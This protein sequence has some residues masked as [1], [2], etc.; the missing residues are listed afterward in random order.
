MSCLRHGEIEKGLKLIYSF[1]VMFYGWLLDPFWLKKFDNWWS[2]FGNWA[3][4]SWDKIAK[5]FV[6]VSLDGSF[7]KML[8]EE[9]WGLVVE[10]MSIKWIGT[11]CYTKGYLLE[12]KHEHQYSNLEYVHFF[13]YISHKN[14]RL[15][16]FTTL[17]WIVL[18]SS[19]DL[20]SNLILGHQAFEVNK[21]YVKII[22]DKNVV[23][24]QIPMSEI[25][26]YVKLVNCLY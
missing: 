24:F 2:F 16:D 13:W 6:N 11:V 7:F 15:F 25:L 21:C 1:F 12:F 18:Q 26:A 14:A 17:W 4:T 5:L 3:K 22:F 23:Y 10:Q 19:T 20:I 9:L 8:F